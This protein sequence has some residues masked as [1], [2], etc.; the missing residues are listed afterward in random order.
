MLVSLNWIKEFTKLPDL[1]A[2]DLSSKLTLSTAEVESTKE[3]NKHLQNIKVVE[4]VKVNPHP[5]AD[6][7]KL[8]TFRISDK[9]TS[10]VVCGA[11]NVVVSMKAAYAPEG[12][13]LP[14][15]LTLTKREIRGVISS[16]MLC[17]KAELGLENGDE[18]GIWHLD[19]NFYVGDS[20]LNVLNKKEDILFD[21][22]NKSLTHRPDLWG[23]YGMAREF[24]AIFKT[25]LKDPYDSQWIKKM[26]KKA[27]TKTKSPIAIEVKKGSA[28]ICYYALS[29][30]GVKVK[31]SP[32]FIKDRLQELGYRSINNLV[33]VSNYVMLELGI[34]LHIFDRKK[35]KGDK[36]I[37]KKL[38][39]DYSFTTLDEQIRPLKADDTVICDR[40]NILCLAGIMGG[41]SSSVDDETTD[42]LIE[43]ANW[44]ASD[45]RRTSTRLS[46]RTEASL[47]YEKSLD[48]HQCLKTLLRTLELVLDLCPKA[49]VVG[50]IQYDG[51]DLKKYKQRVLDI[52]LKKISN[53][54]SHDILKNDISLILKSLGFKLLKGSSKSFKI[55]I[56]SFRAGKDIQCDADIIEEIGRI[57][58]YDNIGPIAPYTELLPVDLSNQKRIKR[59]ICKF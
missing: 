22:D 43:V 7:L 33:D 30:S 31:E 16:G 23:C 21:I 52:S 19:D 41:V 45:I 24:A 39:S 26:S 56:P 53:Y 2:K 48:S 15:G 11:N 47:R 1:L 38:Q 6:K 44:S 51:E 20:L 27:N 9:K 55:E 50:K 57:V 10:E 4:V 29:I 35:I 46:L 40:E 28:G 54:L 37:I 8:V 18:D 49:Y 59:K 14:G 36:L 32:D 17:S 42:I 58:G 3:V 12:T 13:T 5:N 34:P 25:K